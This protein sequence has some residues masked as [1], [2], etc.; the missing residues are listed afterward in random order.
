[1]EWVSLV[2]IID[3]GGIWIF[4]IL[5]VFFIVYVDIVKDFYIYDF[6]VLNEVVNIMFFMFCMGIKLCEVFFFIIQQGIVDY[7]WEV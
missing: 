3:C 2:G 1:M 6:N 5:V 4:D 7:I